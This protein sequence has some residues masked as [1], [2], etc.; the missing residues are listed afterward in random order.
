MEILELAKIDELLFVVQKEEVLSL[1][2]V[3]ERLVAC[4]ALQALVLVVL[5]A[6]RDRVVGLAVRE[7]VSA[8]HVVAVDLW[9]LVFSESCLLAEGW[10]SVVFV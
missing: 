9:R 7:D 2:W 10:L 8:L 4:V 1:D 6:L 3:R 5:V